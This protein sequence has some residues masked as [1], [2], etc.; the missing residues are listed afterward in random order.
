MK[1]SLFTFFAILIYCASASAQAR[2]GASYYGSLSL[3][4]KDTV[5][6][7]QILTIN[8]TAGFDQGDGSGNSMAATLLLNIDNQYPV[9]EVDN[10][11]LDVPYHNTLPLTVTLP[12][13]YYTL[14]LRFD[15]QLLASKTFVVIPDNAVQRYPVWPGDANGDG[16]VDIYDPLALAVAYG[17]KGP[18]RPYATT[19]WKEELC[20]DWDSS[21]PNGANYSHADCNGNGIIDWD[22]IY[23][24]SKNYTSPRTLAP[25][26]VSADANAPLLHFDLGGIVFAQGK[27]VTVPL[28]LQSNNT[29]LKDFYGIATNIQLEGVTPADRPQPDFKDNVL[30]SQANYAY[31]HSNTDIDLMTARTDHKN[32]YGDG[33]VA[34]VSFTLPNG[35]PNDEPIIFHLRGTRI[36]D[37]DGNVLSGYN[38]KDDTAYL[39]TASV[40]NAANNSRTPVIVPN[41]SVKQANL[42]YAFPKAGT[43]EM[44]ITDVTGKLVSSQ[45]ISVA[46]GQHAIAL[47]TLSRGSYLVNLVCKDW[48]YEQ[49]IRWQQL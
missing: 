22:D 17:H 10:L 2:K 26:P 31:I 1:R 4:P 15:G 42:V 41:P 43:I 45:E 29:P 11:R 3:N 5:V 40:A 8:Y 6:Q 9:D 20:A 36:I 33:V 18:N 32:I 47:P 7:G 39:N 46:P 25:N 24:I 23:P 21:F 30:S 49:T 12:E 34:T 19:N 38:V 14:N 13:G 35:L 27:T 48:N 28:K 16:V 37:K 44:Q